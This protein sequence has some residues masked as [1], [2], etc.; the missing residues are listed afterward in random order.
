MN[1]FSLGANIEVYDAEALAILGGL[2]EAIAS[3][4]ARLTPGIYICLDNLNVGR[5]AGN[6]TK[7]S[8]HAAFKK[9]RFASKGWL[10]TGKRLTVQWIPAHTGIER[11]E[12]AE[13][14]AK[15]YAKIGPAPC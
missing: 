14:E 7:G 3:P 6:T 13:K 15:R 2:E 4:M 11:N 8:S 1:G 9:F 10:H 12:I 5:N